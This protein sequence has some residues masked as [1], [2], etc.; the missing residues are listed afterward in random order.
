MVYFILGL[1]I[2]CW[3]WCPEIRS[4]ST[5]WA[6]LSRFHMNTET[7]SET[8]CVLNKIRTMDNAQKH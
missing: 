4:S 6:Q 3:Y 2:L 8:F 5:D 1:Y 7:V